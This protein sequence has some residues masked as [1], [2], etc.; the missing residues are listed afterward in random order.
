MMWM[1]W[2]CLALPILI[3]LRPAESECKMKILT[4]YDNKT[5]KTLITVYNHHW[6]FS[7]FCNL[8]K[9]QRL[10]LNSEH[11]KGYDVSGCSIVNWI[12]ICKF[13]AKDAYSIGAPSLLMLQILRGVWEAHTFVTLN[14]LFWLFYVCSL[15]CMSDFHAWSLFRD[16][17]LLITAITWF[18]WLPFPVGMH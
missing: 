9:H 17:I 14:V 3:V 6:K 12:S 5:L 8:T 11:M 7:S 15:L 16:Y 2:R 4:K 13:S 18:P 1:S 10:F